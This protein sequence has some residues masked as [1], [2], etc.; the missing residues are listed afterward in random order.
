MYA[1]LRSRNRLQ[2]ACRCATLSGHL[3]TRARATHS[4]PNRVTRQIQDIRHQQPAILAGFDDA[5]AGLAEIEAWS[6]EHLGV[7]APDLSILIG[8]YVTL[9]SGM[10][11]WPKRTPAS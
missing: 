7:Y 5:L 3:R 6:S 4:R 2:P 8:C 9:E 10:S 1:R 11:E